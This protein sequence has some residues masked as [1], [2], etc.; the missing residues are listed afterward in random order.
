MSKKFSKK[1]LEY[2]TNDS[3]LL[4]PKDAKELLKEKEAYLR[5]IGAT[6]EDIANGDDLCPEEFW[7]HAQDLVVDLAQALL[8]EREKKFDDLIAPLEDVEREL[9]ILKKAIKSKFK[10]YE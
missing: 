3:D 5:K 1:E 4:Y 7:W 8:D 9:K 6:D 10:G 2:L